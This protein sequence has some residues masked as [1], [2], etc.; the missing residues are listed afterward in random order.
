[1]SHEESL[2]DLFT[3][4]IGVPRF[5]QGLAELEISKKLI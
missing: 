4:Q 1:M 3:F 5:D 2:Q